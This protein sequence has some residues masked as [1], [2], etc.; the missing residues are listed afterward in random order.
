MFEINT[1]YAN[2][3]QFIKM[4]FERPSREQLTYDILD[5]GKT[6]EDNKTA[7]R[8]KHFQMKKGEIWQEAIGTFNT[9]VNLK[10]GHTT[11]LDILSETKQIV[12]ELKNRTNTDNASSKKANLDKLSKF[13][14]ENPTY[15]CIYATINDNTEEKTLQGFRKVILHNGAELEHMA[16]Y[17]FLEF[18]FETYTDDTIKFIKQTI[19][20]YYCVNI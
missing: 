10:V 14:I 17:T 15:K 11:G 13:K 1:Y 19:D 9:Y 20:K 8:V 16:G 2:L 7:L 4:V 5:T 18:I 12:I 3:E 6:M